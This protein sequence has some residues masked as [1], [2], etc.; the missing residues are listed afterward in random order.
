MSHSFL[1]ETHGAIRSKF[2]DVRGPVV[3]PD[4]AVNLGSSRV[5]RQLKGPPPRSPLQDEEQPQPV[6]SSENARVAVIL[7]TLWKFWISKKYHWK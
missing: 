2:L 4:C 6:A 3:T 1:W 7:E 5:F